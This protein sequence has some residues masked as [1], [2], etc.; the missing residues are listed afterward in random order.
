LLRAVDH[1]FILRS[2]KIKRKVFLINAQQKLKRKYSVIKFVTFNEV[3][4]CKVTRSTTIRMIFKN[5]VGQA[6][7]TTKGI[8][9]YLSDDDPF[10]VKCL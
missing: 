8:E 9:G 5:V 10:G 6:P 4:N 7:T 2:A 3:M 1:D